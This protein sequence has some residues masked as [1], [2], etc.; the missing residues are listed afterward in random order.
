MLFQNLGG[1][2]AA[3]SLSDL[4]MHNIISKKLVI[5]LNDP[6][7][8]NYSVVHVLVNSFGLFVC[9]FMFINLANKVMLVQ[10]YNS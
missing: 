8:I 5:L 6:C 9:W 3:Q 7:K 4:E 10:Q 1:M 2:R